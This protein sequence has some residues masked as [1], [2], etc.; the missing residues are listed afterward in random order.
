MLRERRKV[1]ITSA[2]ST[3]QPGEISVTRL[4]KIEMQ[5]KDLPFPSLPSLLPPFPSPFFPVNRAM[6]CSL[7][8]HKVK[9][10]VCLL[11]ATTSYVGSAVLFV[12]L[13]TRLVT[14]RMTTHRVSIWLSRG[15][16]EGEGG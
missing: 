9:A 11:K 14:P 3:I 1:Y 2:H 16:R 15:E 13:S 12:T 7:T 5:S 8:F 6:Q 10:S 4:Q